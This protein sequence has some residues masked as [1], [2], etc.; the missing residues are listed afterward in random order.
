MF[1]KAL[2]TIFVG[3]NLAAAASLAT[4]AN[5]NAPKGGVLNFHLDNEPESLHPI[6]AGDTY[7]TEVNNYIHDSMCTRNLNTWNQ[8]PS[9]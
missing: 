2:I 4:E 7:S 3:L 1:S 8:L 9:V 5:P 6:M